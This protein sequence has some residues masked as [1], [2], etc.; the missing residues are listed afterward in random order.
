MTEARVLPLILLVDFHSYQVRH[1]VCQPV[2]MV[3][4]H[5]HDFDLSFGIGQLA[6]VAEE[7]PVL[8]GQTAKIQIGEDVAQQDQSV[9]TVPPQHTPGVIGAAYFRP[10]VQVGQDERVAKGRT[11]HSNL[12]RANVKGL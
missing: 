4:L 5:P 10:K 2:I 3:A 8:L 12:Y 1:N 7:F 9:E 6:N 11:H